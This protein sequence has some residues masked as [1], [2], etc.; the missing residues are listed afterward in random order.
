MRDR[1]SGMPFLNLHST[2]V[3][4]LH[5]DPE[6]LSRWCAALGGVT[7]LKV[8]VVW[9]GNPRHKGDRQRSLSAEAV[10][11]RLVM[12]GVQLYSLQKEPRAEDAPVLTA[13]GNDIIDLAPAEAITRPRPVGTRNKKSP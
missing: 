2:H 13:L 8:G 5:P 9:A 6:K 4:Y 7:A 10:L 3:P 11:P 12:P 1:P